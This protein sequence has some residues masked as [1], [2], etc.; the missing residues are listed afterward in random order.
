[1][2]CAGMELESSCEEAEK[3]AVVDIRFQIRSYCKRV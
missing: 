1:M 2:S 3:M